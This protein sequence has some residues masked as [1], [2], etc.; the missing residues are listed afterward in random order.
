MSFR[1]L[2][3]EEGFT[4][5]EL[6]VTIAILGIFLAVGG[7]LYFQGNRM[8][9]TTA[10][11]STEKSLGDNMYSFMREKLIYATKLQII[12]P[13]NPDQT[14]ENKKVFK[15]NDTGHLDFNNNN[16]YGEA[17]YSGYTVAYHID[18]PQNAEGSL[19]KNQ[20]DLT[21]Y[22]K[23]DNEIVYQT[24][25]IINNIN[26]IPQNEMIKVKKIQRNFQIYLM[27][28]QSSHL[29]RILLEELYLRRSN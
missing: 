29:K 15:I 28:I 12:D 22:V 6:I 3:M 18:V 8:F 17:Y 16:I 7:T 9:N 23:K 21:V 26:L 20:L 25:S 5:V 4:L 10:V 1:Q 13:Q 11:K 14:P 2:K 19:S 27:I 24:G